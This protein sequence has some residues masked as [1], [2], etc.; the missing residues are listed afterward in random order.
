MA[1]FSDKSHQQG[2]NPSLNPLFLATRSLNA[3]EQTMPSPL[4]SQQRIHSPPFA[5]CS[6]DSRSP[7]VHTTN[8]V[9]VI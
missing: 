5:K 1:I 8:P 4:P 6:N 7:G 2:R 9:K 3:G